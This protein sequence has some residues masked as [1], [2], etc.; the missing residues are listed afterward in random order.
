M[1][2]ATQAMLNRISL[3]RSAE[4]KLDRDIEAAK[5]RALELLS[6]KAER[7]QKAADDDVVSAIKDVLGAVAGT[8]A[9]GGRAAGTRTSGARL[10]PAAGER[11][12]RP[13]T[14]GWQEAC[15]ACATAKRHACCNSRFCM[16]ATAACRACSRRACMRH[17]TYSCLHLQAFGSE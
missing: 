5:R 15:P 6:R 2:L 16:H 7:A 3:L 9:A 14:T 4:T 13:G 1:P 10:A 11:R 8:A 12:A 17:G